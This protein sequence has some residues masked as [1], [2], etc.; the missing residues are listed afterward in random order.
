MRPA[1]LDGVWFVALAA[2]SSKAS[3][4][5]HLLDRIATTISMALRLPF[6]GVTHPAQQVTDYLR[7]KT[8]LL[9]VDNFEHLSDGVDLLVALLQEAPN[10]RLVVT[11]RHRLA[12]QAQLVHQVAG[13]ALPLEKA[14]DLLPPDQLIERY[15]S[16]HL[17][18]E[19]AENAQFPLERN[20]STLATIS[21]LCRV[22]EGVPLAIELAATLLEKQTPDEILQAV[23]THY[24]A[25]QANL[26]DLPQRQRSAQAVLLTAWDLLSVQE[27]QTL[28]RCSVF[29]GGFTLTSAQQI[30]GVMQTDL[31]A[32]INKSLLHIDD[33]NRYTLHELVRQFAAE[34]LTLDE[35]AAQTLHERYATYYLALLEQWQLGTEHAFRQVIQQ[36]IANVEAA[37][38]WALAH[39][40]VR[41]LLA[42]LPALQLFY[43]L[44][45][46]FH[47]AEMQIVHASSQV[48]R[49]LASELPNTSKAE[50]GIQLLMQLL[51]KQCELYNHYLP[52]PTQV[53]TLAQEV[54]QRGE[55]LGRNDLVAE[56]YAEWSLALFALGN[57]TEQRQVVERALPLVQAQHAPVAQIKTL[58]SLGTNAQGQ[59]DFAAAI[60]AHQQAL[61]L[62]LTYQDALLALRILN[63]MAMAYRDSGDLE[64]ALSYF[65]QNLQVAQQLEQA[66]EMAYATA[67]FGLVNLQLGNFSQAERYLEAAR[68][69]FSDQGERRLVAELD[70]VLGL[71]F[72]QTRSDDRAIA[73]CQQTL[74]LA[75]PY[76]YYHAQRTAY[77][78][79]G[80]VYLCRGEI[81]QAETVYH[82]LMDLLQRMDN[83]ADLVYV[84]IG[85]ASVH[86]ARQDDAAA[87]TVIEPALAHLTQKLRP[88]VDHPDLLLSCY[89][90]L[91]AAYDVRAASVLQQAW[92]IVQSQATKIS[93]PALR[94]SFLTNVPVN[95]EL[96]RLV[97]QMPAT[98]DLT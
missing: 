44:A 42:A 64:Q 8:L 33:T 40:Q 6:H 83:T 93:E 90:V 10:L 21:A 11:S 50:A 35:A 68:Q 36:E 85:L 20:P 32:L 98:V 96:G 27:A 46:R 95:R 31:E 80:K 57:F 73:C 71:L 26:S 67:N 5:T 34:Q 37:W 9:I 29:R 91:A 86:S 23:R 75:I 82:Q 30:I 52:Q 70:C 55:Q 89:H 12:F 19:R 81:T 79:L 88:T 18:V 56:G 3:A 59:H 63:H 78:I 62:A 77:E 48:R 7:D 51:L 28:A 87:L 76:Q 54:I 45:C 39:T 49:W 15:A 43:R 74:A 94:A 65:Q 69:V 2:E 17:F 25:L 16:L 84:Q 14:E 24:A 53:I 47:Q 97:A 41:T 72:Q 61:S 13:L 66:N 4:K 58:F 1:F 60:I 92:Q 22:L 38:D